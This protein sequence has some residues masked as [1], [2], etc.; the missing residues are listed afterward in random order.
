MT[1]NSI[2]DSARPA[3]YAAGETQSDRLE[4]TIDRTDRS[5]ISADNVRGTAV[6]NTTG[7][8]IGNVDSVMLDKYSGKVAYAV[9][10]FGGFLGIGEKYHPLP[11]DAL[12]YDEDAG[13]YCVG[14]SRDNL[15][16]GPAYSRSDI[17]S[18][19]YASS[20]PMIDRYYGYEGAAARR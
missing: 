1:N 20:G 6:Y 12:D 18:F 7:E 13:G 10:S 9:M 4:E 17:D 14:I 19:D 15:E 2:P 8:K 11:W 5:L 16:R 3:G